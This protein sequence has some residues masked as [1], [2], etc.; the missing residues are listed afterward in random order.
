MDALGL[1]VKS[2]T[3]GPFIRHSN[4]VTIIVHMIDVAGAA[5]AVA[6]VAVVEVEAVVTI[7]TKTKG[8][9][10][11]QHRRS[12]LYNLSCSLWGRLLL[13]DRLCLKDNP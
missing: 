12:R 1:G 13:K 2:A 6:T 11:D 9:T 7:A 4:I 3:N 8:H 5:V 10:M